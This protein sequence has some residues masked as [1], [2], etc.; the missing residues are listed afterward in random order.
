LAASTSNGASIAAVLPAEGRR[1]LGAELR[2]QFPILD[3]QV[4]GKQLVYL[5]NAATSQKPRQ[6]LEALQNYYTGYNSNVHR[7]V[8][9]LSAKATTEYEAARDKLARFIGGHHREVVFTRG[10]TEAINLV[11]NTWG[12]ANLQPGDEVRV[13]SFHCSVALPWCCLLVSWSIQWHTI[14]HRANL[15]ARCTYALSMRA[16]RP[17]GGGAPQQFGAMADAGAAHRGCAQARAADARHAGAGH[18]SEQPGGFCSLFSCFEVP[19]VLVRGQGVCV[20][21]KAWQLPPA[22][23]HVFTCPYY[24]ASAPTT[25]LPS[26]PLLHEQRST[27]SRCWARARAWWLWCTCQTSLAQCWT[28]PTWPRR[29][30]R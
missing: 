6:V 3:Q 5:D 12:Q 9:T 2:P 14:C 1:A 22:P 16:D 10:A 23:T 7:G 24:T 17:V 20:G 27:S 29:H 13:N 30:A 11:A 4:N 21:H 25:P 28:Q 26:F 8:H 18:D 19:Y 15:P